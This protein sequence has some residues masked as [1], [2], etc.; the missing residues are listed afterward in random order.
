MDT[1]ETNKKVKQNEK[2]YA[3]SAELKIEEGNKSKPGK[4][5]RL[6]TIDS[7]LGRLVAFNMNSDIGK[8]I[9][10]MFKGI[11]PEDAFL[12]VKSSTGNKKYICGVVNKQ[13]GAKKTEKNIYT[14]GWNYSCTG[15][16]DINFH[17]DDI[18]VGIAQHRSL[19]IS[20][21]VI[22][23]KDNNN[24]YTCP[25]SEKFLQRLKEFDPQ[26][27]CEYM[28]ES[29]DCVSDTEEF[30][31]NDLYT[32]HHIVEGTESCQIYNK[33]R[34]SKNL[35]NDTS[36]K[37]AP[38]RNG[39][40][41]EREEINGLSWEMNGSIDPPAGIG[42]RAPTHLKDIYRN[43]IFK[44]E[45]ESLLAFLPISFWL[46]H[47]NECNRYFD[48]HF[49][50]NDSNTKSSGNDY[51][52]GLKWKPITIDELMIFY[53]ILIQMSCRPYPGKRQVDCWN[54]QNEWFTNCRHMKRTRFRQIRSCL[55]WCD[56]ETSANG[57][58]L[59]KVRPM[60]NI[61]L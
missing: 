1:K 61:L 49:L 44:T 52:L 18:D 31:D 33:I 59:Y 27:N 48:Q 10:I 6:N 8:S 41:N 15:I 29:D 37:Y 30:D 43:T 40:G 20:K 38:P 3:V 2:S 47:L 45:L 32:N 25:F 28:I 51:Y 19:I 55:H 58:T 21:N 5:M 56:N 9:D 16:Y 46:Y 14:V 54:Y 50:N 4:I 23:N 11:I 17:I 35:T 57:D 60:I 42:F 13:G 53:A 12:N 7:R 24:K 36:F 39:T 22:I 26:T 34:R